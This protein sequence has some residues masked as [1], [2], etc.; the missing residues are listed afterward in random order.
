RTRWGSAASRSPAPQPTS[1]TEAS[2][3]M[4]RARA[5]CRSSAMKSRAEGCA[6][7][8]RAAR[9]KYSRQAAACASERLLPGRDALG[10]CS[11]TI[12]S[13]ISLAGV[14]KRDHLLELLAGFDGDALALLDRD[15]GVLEGDLVLPAG[16]LVV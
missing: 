16:H 5:C 10:N 3:G 4:S 14:D 13:G 15:L 11:A 2:S 12:P 9:A 7:R 8:S 6:G 1:S